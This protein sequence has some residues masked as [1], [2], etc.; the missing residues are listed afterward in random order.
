MGS[1]RESLRPSPAIHH[2]S[3][4]NELVIIAYFSTFVKG[5][6]PFNIKVCFSVN[7]VFW[8]FKVDISR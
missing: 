8:V 2:F 5:W 7:K 3:A 6:G 1:V 4:T